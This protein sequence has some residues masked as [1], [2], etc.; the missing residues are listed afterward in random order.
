MAI[1]GILV[2]L[3]LPAVQMA[4]ESARRSQCV[5]NLKQIGLA[6]AHHEN[7]HT[8]YPTGG[9]DWFSPPTYLGSTPAVGEE[10]KAGWGFQILPHVEGGAIW[11]AGAE[12]AIATP[13][14][15][16]FCPSRRPP[17]TLTLPDTYVPPVNGGNVTRALSDYAAS[18]RENDGLVR[19]F[20]PNRVS[21]ILDGLSHTLMVGDKR[22]N[23]R[24]LG[25]PQD[26]DNE[27]YCVGW[28][29]DTIRN[30][31]REPLPDFLGSGDGDERFGSSHVGVFNTV[32]ADG[33]IHSLGYGIDKRVFRFLGNIR[34]GQAISAG[35]L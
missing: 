8:F 1:I 14:P 10:Q 17:Q 22:L 34:D 18:N 7:A 32:F 24:H 21:D 25:Q 9:W 3:I 15:V 29:S 28:N 20:K 13:D 12:T 35:D 26:D 2:G 4:R 16:F 6:F 30:T 23:L 19:R 33:S 27:G 5:N 31:D 11:Q